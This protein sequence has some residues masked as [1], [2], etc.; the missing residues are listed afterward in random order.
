[1]RRRQTSGPI[2]MN[3][4]ELQRLAAR[5]GVPL[6]DVRKVLEYLGLPG[7]G[8]EAETYGELLD[9][10]IDALRQSRERHRAGLT[11]Q[12]VPPEFP[13][14]VQIQTIGG[15][16]AA[17]VMCSMSIPEIRRM[18]TGRMS[19]ALFHRLV[20]ECAAREE[21]EELAL[22]LQNEPLLDRELPA[23]IRLVKEL[24]GG[25]LMTRIVTN[26]SLLTAAACDALLDAGLDRI[27]ISV[28]ANS[29]GVY[30]EVMGGLRFERTVANIETLLAKAPPSLFVTL[31]FMVTSGNEHEIAEAVAYWSSRGVLCGAYGI[32]T[33]GGTLTSFDTVRGSAA[34]PQTRECYLPLESMA[35]LCSGEVLLCCTDWSRVSVVGSV[36]G[37][38]IHEVWHSPALAGL[39]REAILDRF[40]HEVC[41]TCIG[42]TRVRHN[43]LYGDGS[44]E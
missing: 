3:D 23:R 18:Q 39:R 42:Q 16:N 7:G 44:A 40:P 2:A 20:S 5:S 4:T 22:Y 17:C 6:D 10:S 33:Q 34:P 11:G 13:S 12:R 35:I 25:R 8:V 21:C 32:N 28:N 15:C 30:E 27:A 9:R 38:T 41:R 31:T 43:L 29:P 26:G 1:M 14:H 19:E 36:A 37:A 24:S